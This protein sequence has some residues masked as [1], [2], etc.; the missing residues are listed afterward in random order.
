MAIQTT[1]AGLAIGLAVVVAA[2]AGAAAQPVPS[3]TELG[4]RKKLCEQQWPVRKK[5]DAATTRKCA[6][7]WLLTYPYARELDDGDEMHFDHDPYV[8]N[9][10]ITI[11]VR[12]A[13][14]QAM[15]AHVHASKPD[16]DDETMARALELFEGAAGALSSLS[17]MQFE[18]GDLGAEL[19]SV[20]QGMPMSMLDDGEGGYDPELLR[21]FLEGVT[22]VTL[23]KLRNAA[24]A[25]W[26]YRFKNPDLDAFFYG[27]RRKNS[28]GLPW[29]RT[30]GFSEKKLTRNDRALIA[31]V[32]AEERRRARP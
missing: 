8:D 13:T 5:S 22:V 24:Y 27:S 32:K 15:A 28:A 1:R 12:R 7:Y 26:G 19:D 17:D 3:R 25:R 2:A 31:A 18:H 20:R 9:L 6:E 16:D 29:P 10:P 11:K 14:W 21:G 4:K 30:P 23:W